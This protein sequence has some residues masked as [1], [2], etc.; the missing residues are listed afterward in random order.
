MD[1]G[2]YK[3]QWSATGNGTY[4]AAA[5]LL[6]KL[7]HEQKI[8]KTT[9]KRKTVESASEMANAKKRAKTAGEESPPRKKTSAEMKWAGDS[10]IRRINAVRN[11]PVK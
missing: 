3:N 8:A 7:A 2:T 4:W 6:A 1:P 11:S 9:G 5:K 10:L